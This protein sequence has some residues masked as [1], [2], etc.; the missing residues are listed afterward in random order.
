MRRGGIDGSVAM[1]ISGHKTNYVLRRYNI[2][3]AANIER[4]ME[5]LNEFHQT[6]DVMLES[7]G[8]RPN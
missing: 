7:S 2:V 1:K 6:E 4:A 3:D 5:R 8:A